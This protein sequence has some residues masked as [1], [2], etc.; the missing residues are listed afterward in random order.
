M[1]LL[2][3]ESHDAEYLLGGPNSGDRGVL[4]TQ[5]ERR[6]QFRGVDAPSCLLEFNEGDNLKRRMMVRIDALSYVLCPPR[7]RGRCRTESRFW[8]GADKERC[9]AA[10]PVHDWT[11]R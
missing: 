5:T 3:L 6:L 10:D 9:L 1:S 4:A 2:S 7:K 8:E 11:D